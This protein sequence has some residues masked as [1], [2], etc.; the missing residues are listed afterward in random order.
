MIITRVPDPLLE[1]VVG[2]SVFCRVAARAVTLAAGPCA[3]DTWQGA[4]ENI[5]AGK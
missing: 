4:Y 1:V 2:M 5:M 3:L